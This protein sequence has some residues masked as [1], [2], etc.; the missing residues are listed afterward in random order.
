[1]AQPVWLARAIKEIGYVEKPT[2]VTKYGEHYGLNG[3]PWCAMF[4]SWSCLKSGKPLPSMQPGMPDG[5]AAVVYAMQWAKA[6]HLWRPSWE[7]APGDAIVYGWAGPSSSPAN[8]HTG[9]IVESGPRGATGRTVEGNRDNRVGRW[10]FTVGEENVLGTI[11]LTQVL[12]PQRIIIPKPVPEP[13]PR[14]AD[15]PD[16]TGPLGDVTHTKVTELADR[17]ANRKAPVKGDGSRRA[18]RRLARQITR[19]LNL[20]ES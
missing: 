4:L 16:N 9:L 17:L 18:L 8:M 10:E 1:M 19:V 7:A 13:Q 3:N 6:H 12:A 5:Y 11:A 2:N 20:K 14:P 15:H